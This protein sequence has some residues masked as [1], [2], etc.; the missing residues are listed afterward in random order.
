MPAEV[1]AESVRP[2]KHSRSVPRHLEKAV[3]SKRCCRGQREA[4]GGLENV[5]DLRRPGRARTSPGSE[6][7]TRAFV[8]GAL[9]AAMLA[10]LASV[11]SHT[12]PTALPAFE[13]KIESAVLRQRSRPSVVILRGALCCRLNICFH[14][15]AIRMRA[16]KRLGYYA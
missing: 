8:R 3:R 13:P 11:L 4:A 10:G 9:C 5:R 15:I 6:R 16:V 12:S 1:G 7:Q 2:I 14:M